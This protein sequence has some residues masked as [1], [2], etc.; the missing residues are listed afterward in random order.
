MNI[1][2]FI[3]GIDKPQFYKNASIANVTVN[4]ETG[5]MSVYLLIGK[6]LKS[7]ENATIENVT[8]FKV[9]RK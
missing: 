2:I 6:T 5:I 1:V 3:S 9:F 7:L 4:K 8:C